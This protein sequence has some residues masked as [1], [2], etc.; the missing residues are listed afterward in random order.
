MRFWVMIGANLHCMHVRVDR[1]F[2]VNLRV[3]DPDPTRRKS[4]RT[5][6]R[7]HPCLHLYEVVMTEHEYISNQ[8]QLSSYFAHP[9]V[10]GVYESQV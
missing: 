7:S 10:E 3:P 6:P 1:R 2:F 5:L 8:R 9:D 4:S